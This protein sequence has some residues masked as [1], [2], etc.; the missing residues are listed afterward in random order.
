[1][2]VGIVG[3]L[4]AVFAFAGVGG[5]ADAAYPGANGK[6]VFE[7]KADQFASNSDPW[8]VSAGNPGTARKLVRIREEASRLRLLAQR[9]EARL[10]GQR[11]V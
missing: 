8:T 2:K 9:Q 11:A 4:A 3:G 7:R 1:M 10:R 5:S 6:I